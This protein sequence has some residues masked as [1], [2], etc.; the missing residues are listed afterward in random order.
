MKTVF[1]PAE[2]DA[3]VL[4][5][6]E[7]SLEKLPK[8]VGVLTTAQHLSQLDKAV[9][10]LKKNKKEAVKGGQVLGC[11]VSNAE[12]IADKVDAFLFIG[13]GK[14]HPLGAGKILKPV[15]CANPYNNEVS[16]IDL[17]EI[18]KISKKR[19]AMLSKFYASD[20]IGV[21][22]ATNA[23]SSIINAKKAVEKYPEKEFFFFACNTLNFDEME[24]FPFVQCWVNTAC[25]RIG[26]DDLDRAK[27]PMVNL[28]DI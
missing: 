28:E 3:D 5:V 10:F 21:I 11:N 27:K 6:V 4:P 25:L 12:K 18:E 26:Y 24:N 13:S 14:F 16:E 22:V 19:Q 9:E 2:V 20:K 17:K 8:K 15:V 23:Q 7:K 1:I